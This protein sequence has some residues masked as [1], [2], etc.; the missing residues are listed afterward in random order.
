MIFAG[1]FWSV[2][3]LASVLEIAKLVAVTWLYRFRSL[4]SRPI[5]AYLYTA[6]I[7]L[8]IVTSLGIF[9]YLT[10]AHI[11]I[12]SAGTSASLTIDEIN[13]RESAITTQRDTL[14]KELAS[15][16][17]QSDKLVDQLGAANR[18][19]RENGAVQV[20]R[21]NAK[22]RDAIL[23]QLKDT[24][25][26]LTTIKKERIG[27]QATVDKATADIGP[28][29]YVAQAI[30]GNE[31][32]DTIR[33]AVIWLTVLLMVVFDPMAVMLLIAANI[34]FLELGRAIPAPAPQLGSRSTIAPKKGAKPAITLPGP[35]DTLSET[36]IE[37]AYV[38]SINAKKAIPAQE[39]PFPVS[40][41]PK[42]MLPPES[43]IEKVRK[44][45]WA[46]NE[47][48]AKEA[49]KVLDTD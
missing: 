14:T 46:K 35:L 41:V 34:L 23:A 20:Q 18:L 21:E 39:S 10:R 48:L 36:P 6:T 2:V 13:Q 29:R 33:K 31:N 28:L 9:G 12:E 43:L 26:Q 37:P 7:L 42:S 16:S 8:M 24:N 22:R 17:S 25:D 49:K 44:D 32:Q 40:D 3:V 30:Y 5:R 11:D 1:S 47:F 38:P 15:V 45:K 19:T 4:A 27:T